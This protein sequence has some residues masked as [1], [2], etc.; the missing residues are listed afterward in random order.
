MEP[1]E[2]VIAACEQAGE[3]LLERDVALGA[4]SDALGDVERGGGAVVL[5]AGTAGI[6]K[7]SLVQAG[8]RA[9]QEAGFRVGSASESGSAQCRS[10]SASSNGPS[11]VA[12]TSHR[13]IRYR[14][15]EGSP[16]RCSSATSST[17]EPPSSTNA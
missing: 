8:R 16:R 12:F 10:S 2:T 17:S 15:A 14:R 9:A 5:L 11:A 13:N 7:T 4:I 3:Q 1:S 6:G